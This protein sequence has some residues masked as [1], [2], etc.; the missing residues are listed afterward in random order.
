MEIT[1]EMIDEWKAK[2]GFVY[3]ANFSGQDFYFRTL[4]R[5]DYM[6]IQQKV[7][8]EGVNFDNE[9]EVVQKCLLEPKLE[10]IELKAKAG[11]ISVLS[12]KIMLRS[13][14]QQVEEEEL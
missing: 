6:E 9:L 3:R 2:H 5:D 12:E 11:L 8:T 14:F 4:T 13:G 10:L 7:A 1:Q